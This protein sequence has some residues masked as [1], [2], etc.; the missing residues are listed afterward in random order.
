[1]TSIDSTMALLTIGLDSGRP[2]RARTGIATAPTASHAS[3]DTAVITMA[4]TARPGL[5]YSVGV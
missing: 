1:M 3:G 2:I 5:S 4:A